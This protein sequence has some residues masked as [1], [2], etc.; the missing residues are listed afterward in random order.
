[1]QPSHLRGDNPTGRLDDSRPERY[2]GHADTR[3]HTN[4]HMVRNNNHVYTS[5]YDIRSNLSKGH[6][7]V[8]KH[9]RSLEKR[10]NISPKPR[11]RKSRSPTAKE[12]A[13]RYLLPPATIRPLC[14]DEYDP[15]ALTRQYNY[16]ELEETKERFM[17]ISD[18][19]LQS[20][21][22][23]PDTT[24]L[25]YPGINLQSLTI[26]INSGV[27]PELV[28]PLVLILAVGTNNIAEEYTPDEI[29]KDVQYLL[30]E[31]RA[32]NPYLHIIILSIIPRLVDH[33]RTR[34]RVEETNARLQVNAT[35]LGYMYF[36]TYQIFAPVPRKPYK[37]F[38]NYGR[39]HLSRQGTSKF[40]EC[41][42]GLVREVSTRLGI[43]LDEQQSQLVVRRRK[44][45]DEMV[46][47]MEN[48]PKKRS[49]H[50]R[51][52]P[53]VRKS[54]TVEMYVQTEKPTL[55]NPFY[56]DSA[57]AITQT[58][59]DDLS[60]STYDLCKFWHKAQNES[61]NQGSNPD[62]PMKIVPN[63]SVDKATP[64]ADEFG[65]VDDTSS[66]QEEEGDDYLLNLDISEEDMEL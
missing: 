27:V 16:D 40:V 51:K 47:D 28:Y 38:Y 20:V 45:S 54:K 30:R 11:R 49:T 13:Q 26:L 33:R 1:M 24:V 53:R 23:V 8:E 10:M 4:T 35:L 34:R 63:P 36:D 39:L 60:I 43:G 2:P 18:S 19:L 48:P 42:S 37:V 57:D 56:D 5:H 58:S 46:K 32:H 66:K 21:D 41:L 3:S 65:P 7:E 62:E 25:A 14:Q 31:I 59:V 29:M 15:E 17:I 12:I 50:Q 52:I 6:I 55:V 64:P 9:I 44:T 61:T 22:K